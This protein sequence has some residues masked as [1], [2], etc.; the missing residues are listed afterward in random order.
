MVV[1]FFLIT[2]DFTK[3]A[4]GERKQ[5]AGPGKKLKVQHFLRQSFEAFLKP[6]KPL[7]PSKARQK[8]C[9]KK[10][11]YFTS[12]HTHTPAPPKHNYH[13]LSSWLHSFMTNGL[14]ACIII[15][16]ELV[17]KAPMSFMVRPSITFAKDKETKKRIL[18]RLQR[19]N[20]H[21]R[22]EQSRTVSQ[23]G[24]RGDSLVW[25]RRG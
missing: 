10:C 21:A 16:S 17:A 23:A 20:G 14:A 5:Q 9:R 12:P 11:L 2:G 1:Q 8:D 3:M 19:M 6:S 15:V 13:S 4:L 22:H 24:W 7:K 25:L 18:A